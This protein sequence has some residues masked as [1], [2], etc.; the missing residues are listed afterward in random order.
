MKDGGVLGFR[1]QHGYVAVKEQLN[2]MKYLP[3]LLKGSDNVVYSVAKLLSLTVRVKPVVTEM[4]AVLDEFQKEQ[5]VSDV[6]ESGIEAV[7]DLFDVKFKSITWATRR[8]KWPCFWNEEL[9]CAFIKYGNEYSLNYV[10]QQAAILIK[11]PKWCEE[12]KTCGNVSSRVSNDGTP[13]EKKPCMGSETKASDSEDSFG[14]DDE[15]VLD[16]LKDFF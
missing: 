10:Y 6:Y 4:N 8:S 13:P 3:V 9:A 15:G 2:K 11:V 14:R 12:R 1:C 5:L 7:Q 16:S